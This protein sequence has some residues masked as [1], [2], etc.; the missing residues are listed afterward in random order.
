MEAADDE[1]VAGRVR[2]REGEALV[3]TGV[4]EWVEAD[5]PDALDRPAAVRLEDRGPC[6]QLVELAPDCPYLLEVRVEDAI[7]GLAL[8]STGQDRDAPPDPAQLACHDENEHEEDEDG[9]AEAE[10]DRAENRLDE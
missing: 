7:E 3:A 10:D 2:Q 1:P 6:G 9:Q 4:L 8:P 5:E